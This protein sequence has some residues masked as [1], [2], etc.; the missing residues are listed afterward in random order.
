MIITR[1][2]TRQILQVTA[3]LSLILLVVAVLGR[4]L[5]YLAQASQGELDPGVLFLL[6]G[7]RLPDFLQLILPIALLLGILLAYGR[8]YA[9]SEMTV[10]VACGVDQRRLLRVTLLS[11]GIVALLTA[12]LSLYLTPRSMVSTSNLLEAQKNLSE[13]DLLVPG[14]F[15][16]INRGARTTYAERIDARGMHEVFM[17]E[18]AGNRVIVAETAVPLE[19]AGGERFILFRNGSVTQGVSGEEGYT[20]TRFSELGVR[21][22]PRQLSFEAALEEQAMGNRALLAA[23]QPQ[24]V[25]ELQWRLSLALFIPV[26]ALLAVPL[27]KVSPRQGRFA[28]LVPA[29]LLYLA[30]FGLLLICR[31]QVARGNL[32]GWLGLW[33]V[34]G[35][36]LA[37]GWALFTERLSTEL[38]D[39]W[40]HGKA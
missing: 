38:F 21:L 1:Y 40:R 27:S 9:D 31:E 26:L 15:Q 16:D 34:H 37:L 12:S 17:H 2:L 8:M 18:S 32:P 33:W 30:Y 23:G 11:A 4:L 39:R 19:D 28:R 20:L 25:A 36:F 5:K 7:Y 35:L 10:L 29:V 24:H 6:M 22:P 13:F 3:A 14:L